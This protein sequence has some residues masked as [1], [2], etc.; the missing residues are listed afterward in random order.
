MSEI[1]EFVMA[2]PLFETHNHQGGFSVHNWDEKSYEEFASYATADF[3]SAGC[4]WNEVLG[5]NEK[6]FATW[7]FVR[8]TG[9]G[10]AMEL[11]CRE[12]L[13]LEYTLEN[14]DAITAGL[15]N[16]A[17][18]K[19][20]KQVTEELFAKAN[21]QWTINDC[22]HGVPDTIKALEGDDFPE[23]FR[24]VIRFEHGHKGWRG[25]AGASLENIKH[26]EEK[27]N[28][29]IQSLS[30][31]DDT[32]N[33]YAQQAKETGKLAGYKIG[34]AYCRELNFDDVPATA[35]ENV[36]TDVLSGK[37]VNTKPLQDYLVHRVFQRAETFNL[38]V[39]IH[40]GYLAGCNQDIRRGDP[41]PLVPIFQKYAN[42]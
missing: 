19:T 15:R 13:G 41:T 20:N 37:D 40:T 12:L 23:S 39:Q 11:G 9:Y 6:F 31:L 26:L 22:N 21:V 1:R 30:D 7:P 4:S 5:N 34:L 29:S 18:G 3:G 14:V 27:F 33:L 42:V 2:Q 16:L 36:F 32:L 8:T 10:R 35:A 17:H 38:P 28:V 25:P 24:H